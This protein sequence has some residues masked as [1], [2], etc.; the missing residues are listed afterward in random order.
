MLTIAIL[1][2]C[3]GGSMAG[4]DRG[5]SDFDRSFAAATAEAGE[6]D[7]VEPRARAVTYDPERELVFVEFR[8]GF[9]FGIPP[10]R[11]AGLAQASP[12]QIAS[13]RISPSGDGLIWEELDTHVSL[14]GL[15]RDGLNL[16]EWAPR[17]MG[18]QRSEAKAR[19]ARR[20]GLKGGRPRRRPGS[21]GKAEKD[22]SG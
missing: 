4:H 5:S 21:S 16:R 3:G 6:A 1:S 13:V 17:L 2:K 11:V 18:Q 14:T 20:N 12:S 22:P 7:R 19:A 9:V 15:V 10:S 8:S